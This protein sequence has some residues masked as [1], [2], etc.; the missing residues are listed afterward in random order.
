MNHPHNRWSSDFLLSKRRDTDPLAD[1]LV[2]TII[3]RH[4][5]NVFHEL[6]QHLITNE[7]VDRTRLPPEAVRYFDETSHLPDYANPALMQKGQEVFA[8]HGLACTLILLCKSLPQTYACGKGVEVLYQTGRL[9]G[10]EHM[11]KFTRRLMET[12]QFVIDVMTPGGLEKGGRGVISAQKVRLIHASIRVYLKQKDWDAQR[13]DEPINQEDMAGTLMAFSALVVQG[14]ELLG[15]RLTDDEK[16]AYIHT[17]KVVG[18]LMGVDRSLIPEDFFDAVALGEAIFHQQM[19]ASE[20]GRVLTE[21]CLEFLRQKMPL[22]MAEVPRA[23]VHYL[24]GPEAAAAVGLKVHEN[25]LDRLTE[26]LIGHVF[27]HTDR[28]RPRHER[29]TLLSE[30]LQTHIQQT[31]INHF[32]HH[33]QV[34]FYIPPSLRADW[35]I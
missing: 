7:G 2:R 20:A 23:M 28:D 12:A 14:L 22:H 21:A 16:E 25:W 6:W 34:M 8:R 29:L 10:E 30:H 1:E 4:R 19:Q 33:K 18:H 24:I 35:K 17:W 27:A 5:Q 9:T 32:N 3:D 11:K 31:M 13:F 26:S 15:I